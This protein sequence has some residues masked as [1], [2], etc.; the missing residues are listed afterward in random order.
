MCVRGLVL[1]LC[2]ERAAAWQL[3][4]GT[5][6]SRYAALAI[7]PA[8]QQPRLLALRLRMISPATA[9]PT[10]ASTSTTSAEII[11]K[12]ELFGNPEYSAGV[13]INVSVAGRERRRRDAVNTQ[14]RS[15]LSHAGRLQI[16]LPEARRRRAQRVGAQRG[17]R[18]R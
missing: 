6:A 2:V 10:G 8:Q 9:Q 7:F 3:A 12:T 4:T 16:S 17:G 11:P 14:V 13:G 1:L 15:P 18:R 5:R